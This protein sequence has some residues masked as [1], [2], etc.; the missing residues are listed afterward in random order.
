VLA[1]RGVGGGGEPIEEFLL[2]LSNI[3][4][5]GRERNPKR[6]NKARIVFENTRIIMAHRAAEKSN[7]REAELRSGRLRAAQ[8]PS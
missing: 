7:P 4:I 5:Q 3:G 6:P 8:V 2:A 1:D